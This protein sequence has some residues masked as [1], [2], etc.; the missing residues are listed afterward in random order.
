MSSSPQCTAVVTGSTRGLG[1]AIARRLVHDGASVVVSGRRQQDA[2]RAARRLRDEGPGA[3]V[4]VACDVRRPES[5]EHLLEAAARELG[6]I[7]ALVANAGVATL[8]RFLDL[9]LS[10]WDEVMSVNARGVFLCG[11]IFARHMLDHDGGRIINIG[12]QAGHQ[13]QALVA[14]Y[15]ASKAAILGLTKAMAIELAPRLQVN[16]VC[17]GIVQTDMIEADF[18]RQATILDLDPYEIARG[19]LARIPLG[20][21]QSAESVA[22]TVAFLLSEDAADITGQVVHVN[23]GM[24]TC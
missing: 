17:P 23:G 11:Q 13:G 22:A 14:H 24:T 7:N 6:A 3:V 12:S 10:E 18:R 21:F 1:F 19:T 20:R 2:E 4:A 15:C 5:V 16:A 8:G 9:P